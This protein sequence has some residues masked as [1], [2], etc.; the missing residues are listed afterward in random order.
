MTSP[1]QESWTN[2]QGTST[3]LGV[4]W[5]YEPNDDPDDF[6]VLTDHPEHGMS[7]NTGFERSQLR[8]WEDTDGRPSV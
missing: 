6:W 2:Y 1:G 5:G 4:L 3:D 7:I 8:E